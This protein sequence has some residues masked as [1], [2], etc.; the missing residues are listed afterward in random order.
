MRLP[1]SIRMALGALLFCAPLFS[2]PQPG[3]QPQ[4]ANPTGLPGTDGTI[5]TL[6][7]H[8]GILYVG[9]KFTIAGGVF[10]KNI[11]QWDGK[12][13]SPLGEGLDGEITKLVCDAKGNL[14]A[15]ADDWEFGPKNGTYGFRIK[16]PG[17]V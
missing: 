3:S 6:A 4:V 17:T 14:Y 13:W 7:Y 12:S 8:Q 1:H 15:A 16:K 5:T 2:Q 11:A 9:G 10:A